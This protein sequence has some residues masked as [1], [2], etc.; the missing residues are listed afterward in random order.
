[1]KE[2]SLDAK[3]IFKSVQLTDEL[4]DV[5][6][7]IQRMKGAIDQAVA[8]EVHGLIVSIPDSDVL[9]ESIANAVN[10][11]IPVYAVY[12]GLQAAKKLGIK[13]VMSDEYKAGKII[14]QNLIHD[15]VNDFVCING[16]YRIPAL[17]D[18][19]QGVLDSFVEAGEDVSRNISDHLIFTQS[20]RNN[21]TMTAISSIVE[22][23][24]NKKDVTGIVYLT[25]PI[26]TDLGP[27]VYK[28]LN[29]SRS[30]KFA[31]FD[32][33][34]D[35]MNNFSQN[36]LH[37]SISSLMYLQTLIPIILL[38]VQ[39]NAGEEIVQDQILTG[40]KLVTPSNAKDMLVQESWTLTVFASY[41]KH[42][43]VITAR[44]AFYSISSSILNSPIN[45]RWDVV[46][47]GARDA[48]KLMSWD[49]TEYRYDAP[50][51]VEAVQD[52]I[53]FV[54]RDKLI[55]GLIMSNANRD[56]INSALNYTHQNITLRTAE[57]EAQQQLCITQ[58]PSKDQPPGCQLMPFWN[59]TLGRALPVPIVG[60]GS[61]YNWPG[62][63]SLSWVGANG[64]EAGRT[65]AD[66][67]FSDGL[68]RPICIVE[69]NEP[70][71]QMLACKG[72]YDSMLEKLIDKP[73]PS[74]ETFTVKL[75]VG[76]FPGAN[77]KIREV[78]AEYKFDCIHTVSTL[79]YD[80]IKYLVS[81]GDISKSI[82]L[83][84]SGKSMTSLIDLATKNI[85]DLW[86]QQS[87]LTGFFSVF[88][89]AFST[90]LQNKPW[91][92]IETAPVKVNYVC[93]KGQIISEYRGQTSLYCRSSSGN[94]VVQ[95]LCTVCPD[96]TY[97]SE[98]DST[99]CTP[100]AFG[101]FTLKNS[102][103]SCVSC[104]VYGQTHAV[105]NA[106]FLKKGREPNV[107][108][109][110]TLPIVSV[111]LLVLLF[112]VYKRYKRNR[113]RQSRLRDDS[114]ILDYKRIMGVYH[115]SDS[116][117]GTQDSG[118]IAER[119]MQYAN[120]PKVAPT[121]A[122]PTGMFQRSHSTFVG[123]PSGIKPMDAS[124]RAIGVYR[125]LPV[126]VRRIGGTKV[127]LTGKIRIEIMDVMEL[128]H[129]K[130][131]ELVGVCLQAP[132]ICIVTEHCSK[133]TLNEVL[134]NPDLNFNWLFKLSFMS[135]ISRGME[136]L[137]QSKIQFHGDLRS[138][139]CLITSRW[140]V[141]IGGYG[142]SE[143]YET[144]QPGYGRS[145]SGSTEI[146][147]G[148]QRNSMRISSDSQFMNGSL[149]S[150]PLHD[151]SR[152]RY[153]EMLEQP[154]RLTKI[155][156]EIQEGRWV[157]PENMI[158]RGSILHRSST[159]AGDVF[160]AGII[161]NEIMTRKMPYTRQLIDMDTV[162]GPYELLDKIKY[163][164]LRPDFLLDDGSDESIGSVNQLIRNCLQ[165]DP[166][167][168]P[169]FSSILHRLRV[170]SPDGDM[171]GGMA[172]LL[173]KYANDMEELV[174]TRTMHLQT[175]TQELEDERLRTEALLIDLNQAKNYAEEAARAKANFLANMSH[176]I[177]TPMNAVIGMSRIL[178]E[179]DL[180]PDLM[181]YAETIE[182]SGNQLMAVIDDI[183][184]FSKIESGKL[185]LSPETLDLPWLV[186]SVCNLVS[187]QAAS[188]GL[189]LTFVLHP[190]TPTQALGD[191]VRIRQILLNLLSNA[192]KF[193]DIGNIVVKL[194]PKP[195]LSNNA[196]ARVY[197]DDDDEPGD[198]IQESSRLMIHADQGSSESV[199]GE[200]YSPPKPGS[201][202]R[203][204]LTTT[205]RSSL[206]DRSRS[207]DEPEGRVDLLWS[208]ADQGCGIPEERMDRLFK[209]FSQAD[210]SV[211]R[212]FGG[213]GLGLAISKK[214]VELMDG[215]MWVE[216]EEGVGST[217]YFTTYLE[218]PKDCQTV[219]E[220]QNLSFFG[221]KKL[222]ILDDKRVSRTSWQY[223]SSTWGFN[224]TT[225]LSVQK[226]LAYLK[227]NPTMVDV[228]MIDVDK[229]QAKVNPGLAVLEQVRSIACTDSEQE[230][231]NQRLENPIP[232]VLVS[233]HRRNY[234]SSTH[235]AL[236]SGSVKTGATGSASPPRIQE[237]SS[238]KASSAGSSSHESL[239][240]S[241][242]NGSTRRPSA[243][244]EPYPKTSCTPNIL[245]S[246]MLAT[247][248]WIF[249]K[250][251]S[252]SISGKSP[253]TATFPASVAD[254]DP[255]L[256]HLIK[257]VKQTKLF[258]MFHGLMTG[259]WPVAPL[260]APDL[261]HRDHERK[262][263]LELL[264]CLLVDDNPVNQK[265]ISRML[266]RIGINPELANNGQEAVDK[267]LARAKAVAANRNSDGTLINPDIRQYDIIFIDVWMPVKDGLQATS[268]IRSTIDG[269]TGTDPFIIAMTAC[270]MPGDREKCIESGMNAYLSKPIKKEEL[271][272][273]LERWLDDR[274]STQ[275]EKKM[276]EEKKLIQKKK[277]EMLR[278][279]SMA[280]LP[281]LTSSASHHDEPLPESKS[282][283][284][285]WHQQYGETSDDDDDDDESDSDDDSDFESED[286][287][288]DDDEYNMDSET[289]ISD[290][291]DENESVMI[292]PQEGRV[293]YK[294]ASH[295]RRG[296]RTRH[297]G[298]LL[299]SDS[300]NVLGCRDGG[301]GG[302]K[303][304]SLA[305]NGGRGSHRQT[306]K[307]KRERRERSKSQ[308]AERREKFREGGRS[309]LGSFSVDPT[310][311][312][313]PPLIGSKAISNTNSDSGM[314]SDYFGGSKKAVV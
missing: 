6:Y 50:V 66:A 281:G 312:A 224:K 274:S 291:D 151:N 22:A 204:S 90:V 113:R 39:L 116:G 13:A 178:L 289:E 94:H 52:S 247:K 83:T 248:P 308:K 79:L 266:G 9:H 237:I 197:E 305:A 287:N 283:Y 172:A 217:F 300:E 89:L 36:S 155:S 59:Y 84:A 160:S 272:D 189:G 264:Q 222:L 19:C 203:Q 29:N 3:S 190:D 15:G 269:I 280:V 161:F 195:K 152:N 30:F 143:L 141:K 14:G 63:Q 20:T 171:I 38:F 186:E 103:S 18:R 253:L 238:L 131:V 240:D 135:D 98:Y 220:Q 154:Y 214:L 236:S 227:Q 70:M 78:E 254:T 124:G 146:G 201:R 67:I 284:E 88:E 100:C 27:S 173:E 188:K 165:P 250:E 46:S 310:T 11:G 40:P 164:N 245:N 215:E 244:D 61:P 12:S 127:S 74:F 278:R 221:D 208:V 45:E 288:E 307:Q 209:S 85:T 174:R 109:A 263:Q 76:D 69:D 44:Q 114:W 47:T 207:R 91:N 187:M 93:N 54:L 286:D 26:Y 147:N 309:R 293:K 270:V 256:G 184:D 112:I 199:L 102:S 180:S 279:R 202:H 77:R 299:L 92:F 130:L 60:I 21:G 23:I 271:S 41:A 249:K 104:D 276:M 142:L 282:G 229:P 148:P 212:N 145:P 58:S 96:Q 2:T 259:S 168:R 246:G 193:T 277:R 68:R 80:N 107:T 8:D 105:C 239:A 34:K 304:V 48:A 134:A 153:M 225:V 122:R 5:E 51:R 17:L 121:N 28:Q 258:N 117:L 73:F 123:G 216:S 111:F 136:F 296:Q 311:G 16:F 24:T 176:E 251:R 115:D 273:V 232:C 297:R 97:S 53:K 231:D 86:S 57:I 179:S 99:S 10:K 196:N 314:D 206:E 162:E 33:N 120:N 198:F 1:M 128:R 241:L 233:Y 65:Y 25:S 64:Y 62:N 200:I 157:A 252:G 261:D 7:D 243:L 267:C 234:Q 213:T 275:R 260:V 95:P 218:S 292:A 303:M 177:R 295:P 129:P 211:T 306:S 4:A 298:E 223:Q 290:D 302:L 183:L 230:N 118:S 72:L 149:S 81:K 133:G 235:P 49:M 71:Q 140:E 159:R 205:I 31:A 192:I 285:L 265:V 56:Y 166:C 119:G 138:S 191:L 139:N 262:C 268:E 108:L 294:K 255:S 126:F 175:R 194:E 242:K 301:G 210:E 182:S 106:Y 181:D 35:M 32:F 87:Y 257:P 132:D 185:K 170:I 219:A 110:V 37:Y 137:H 144:Q 42:F 163:E 167:L 101:T 125:N 55:Q 150:L 43:G 226:G 169:S 313:P 82:V 75:T 156:T 158:R 228:I